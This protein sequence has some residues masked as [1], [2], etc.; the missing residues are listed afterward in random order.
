M[1]IKVVVRIE[2]FFSLLNVGVVHRLWRWV[3]RVTPKK[4]LIGELAYGL[5]I[6]WI[7]DLVVRDK[8]DLW[9]GGSYS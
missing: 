9:V 6:K 3:F 7:S 1:I 2:K 4:T 5:S 8:I